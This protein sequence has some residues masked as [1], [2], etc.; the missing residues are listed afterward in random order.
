[1]K[2]ILFIEDESALQKTFGDILKNKGYGVLKA[3][4]GESGLRSAQGERPDLILLDLIL[5]KMDGFEVLKELKEN[6]ETKNIPVIILTN[7]EETED[8]QKALEL[9]ATTYLVKSSY[10]LEEV[11]NKIEKALGE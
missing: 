9:G 4:D 3:L 5:P 6:E 7:L 1:M 11:V 10:T 8:I 2:K